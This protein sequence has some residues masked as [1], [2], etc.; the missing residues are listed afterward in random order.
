MA[1]QVPPGGGPPPHIH[2]R[3]EEQFYILQ[4]EITLQAGDQTI[5]AYL[6]TWLSYKVI[7]NLKFY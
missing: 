3:E 2:H 4:G 5:Q 7:C 6:T 1:A